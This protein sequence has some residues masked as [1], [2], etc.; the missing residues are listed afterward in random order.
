MAI[1][2]TAEV[3][4]QTKEGY[5]GMMSMLGTLMK[6]APGFILQ[7]SYTTPDSVWRV[8]EVWESAKDANQFFAEFIHPNLPAG[9]K[10]K[11]IFH[12]LHNVLLPLPLEPVK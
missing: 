11:R 6:Q 7:A 5:D 10:P 2:I 12:D 3:P 4:G 8:I 1:L 9:V